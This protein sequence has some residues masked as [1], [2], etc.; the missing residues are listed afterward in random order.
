MKRKFV[1]LYLSTTCL[2][3]M[4]I[5]VPGDQ[6]TI[7]AGIDAAVNGD[8]IMVAA[9]IYSGEGNRD[10]DFVG[11]TIT[12]TSSLGADSTIINCEGS[13]SDRHRGFYFHSGES[14][15]SILEGFTVMNG[16]SPLE[17]T[18]GV[19]G[20][21]YC[22]NSSPTIRNNI[23][24][25][26]QADTYGGGILCKSNSS[27]LVNN[28]EII[29]N[30]A[31]T[32]GGIECQ[33]SS[34]IIVINNVIMGNGALGGG[35]LGFRGST[36]E[37]RN[38]LIARNWSVYGSAAIG[39]GQSSVIFRNNTITRNNSDDRSCFILSEAQNV[40]ITNCIIMDNYSG[41]NTQIEIIDGSSPTVNY[42]D[43][44]GGWE[45]IGNISSEPHFC[46]RN[47]D[48]FSLM[49][50]SPC[51]GT[52]ENGENIGAYDI[53]CDSPPVSNDPVVVLPEHLV[54]HSNYPNPFNPVTKISYSLPQTTAVT[55]MVY[56]AKGSV[57]TTLVN[58]YQPAGNYT[59]KWNGNDE[60]GNSVS[61]GVYFARLQA[62]GLSTAI[63][64]VY[65][66]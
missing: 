27:P 41:S 7:Q 40:V 55:L 21:I 19:G 46:D 61:A 52:G 53:G 48:D 35:G 62:G 4:I 59:I 9:G 57:T 29:D 50:D 36:A 42:S 51:I 32:G 13:Y 15:L 12:V 16:Y 1:I 22:N 3:A 11:K 49:S 6:A 58:T 39:C 54:L 10:I 34:G 2:Y 8:T 18:Y 5:H 26:N 56:N 25:H 31:E 38:N 43:I 30:S 20:G 14:H 66:K 64:M 47:S 45:G 17:D 63:K 60:S 44:G 28:N 23:I 33:Y 65:L 37:V 24:K